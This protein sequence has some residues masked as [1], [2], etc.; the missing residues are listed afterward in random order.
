MKIVNC[1]LVFESFL[2]LVARMLLPLLVMLALGGLLLFPPVLQAQSTG[3]PKRDTVPLTL[4][5]GSWTCP[6]AAFR[7]TS[8][9]LFSTQP[10]ACTGQVQIVT[11]SLTNDLKTNLVVTAGYGIHRE[12]TNFVYLFNGSTLV[13]TNFGTNTGFAR[14]MGEAR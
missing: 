12:N 13:Y 1:K 10:T 7:L 14:V 11:D 2:K 8:V 4:G 6:Y 3:T 9:E 5:A